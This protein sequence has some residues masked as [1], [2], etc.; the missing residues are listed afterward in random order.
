MN[1][2]EKALQSEDPNETILQI[3]EIIW[4]KTEQSDDNFSN[5]TS[6]EKVFIFIDMLE[7][8][9]NNGGFDQFFF[10]ST[11]TYAHECL[12]AYNEIGAFKTA[13]IIYEAIRN[14][15]ELPVPKD[16]ATRRLLMQNLDNKIVEAWNA[17]D[18]KFY[19]YE[20]DIAGLVIDYIR[21]HKS[22]IG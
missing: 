8:Q 17:L 15:P 4:K 3:G 13:E 5:L 20:E 10:N 16:T 2:I 19:E 6:P 14:F 18:D 1:P 12:D 22:E 11:G 7:A 21:K 9:V